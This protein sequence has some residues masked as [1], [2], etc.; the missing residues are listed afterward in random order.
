MTIMT[1]RISETKASSIR[2]SVAA[3]IFCLTL[4]RT[5]TI[6]YKMLKPALEMHVSQT[7]LRSLKDSE[8]DTRALKLNQAEGSHQLFEIQKQLQKL[9]N[10]WSVTVK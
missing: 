8:R 1:T 3:H 5:A 6:P 7:C 9:G 4:R 2:S 10:W